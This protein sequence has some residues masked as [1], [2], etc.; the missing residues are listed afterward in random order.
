MVLIAF[1]LGGWYDECISKIG[2]SVPESAESGLR[3]KGKQV[4][5]LRD[6][7][8]VSGEHWIMR[9][10]EGMAATGFWRLG[11]RSLVC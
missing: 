5:D 2:K 8:T 4:K 7:V 1:S 11:R 10:P 9:M 3:V 6:L